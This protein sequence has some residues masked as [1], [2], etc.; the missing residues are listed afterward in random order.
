VA[1]V[2]EGDGLLHDRSPPNFAA[3][4]AL[5]ESCGAERV[6]T[7]KVM[8][9]LVPWARALLPIAAIDRAGGDSLV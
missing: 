5:C 6:T 4:C 8:D 2:F 3:R 7:K 9:M 1:A